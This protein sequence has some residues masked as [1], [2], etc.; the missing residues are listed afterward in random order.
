[1]DRNC[2]ATSCESLI[3]YRCSGQVTFLLGILEILLETSNAAVSNFYA[4]FIS[5]LIVTMQGRVCCLQHS[6]QTSELSNSNPVTIPST[7]QRCRECRGMSAIQCLC[8]PP[9]CWMC[10]QETNR[11]PCYGSLNST[12][13]NHYFEVHRP[14]ISMSLNSSWKIPVSQI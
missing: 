2:K 11:L 10:L 6:G 14:D 13:V 12:N 3:L 5:F 7:L 9:V 4:H 8:S 1:M